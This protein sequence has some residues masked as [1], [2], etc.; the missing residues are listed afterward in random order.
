VNA[1]IFVVLFSFV[2]ILPP[3]APAQQA[4]AEAGAGK[5]PEIT[6]TLD[7]PASDPEHYAL[8]VMA[9][10]RARYESTTRISAESDDREV[11]RCEFTLSPATR[12]RV[13]DLAAQTQFFT[14]KLDSG[15]RKLAF[16]GAKTLSYTDG[17]RN[18]TAT[19]NYTPLP[20]AQEITTLFQGMS[21]TLEYGRRLSYFHQHQKLGLDEELK[22]MES[23]VA[24]NEL[25]ELGAV[26]PVLRAIVEDTSVINVVRARALRLAD[27]GKGER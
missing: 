21:A 1:A 6:F 14:R 8:N 27:L 25:K 16:T 4:M 26:E 18:T 9:D 19:F 12:A 22:R 15:N 5:V 23:Q 2:S 20:A 24:G 11:Y 7:F 13:F 17:R 10:G 3:G